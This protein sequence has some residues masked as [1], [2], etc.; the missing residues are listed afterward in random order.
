MVKQGHIFN[1]NGIIFRILSN[2]D[3]VIVYRQLG[4]PSSK[5]YQETRAN[6]EKKVELNEFIK[7]SGKIISEPRYNHNKTIPIIGGDCWRKGNTIYK[8]IDNSDGMCVYRELGFP[9]SQLFQDTY[10]DFRKKILSGE[11]R[12]NIFKYVEV[13]DIYILARTNFTYE[14]VSIDRNAMIIKRFF[15]NELKICNNYGLYE[16]AQKVRSGQFV[17]VNNSFN[18][19]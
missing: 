6:F 10:E 17:L 7:V 12:E 2:T 14:I 8:I 1:Q 19:H 3:G 18:E 5:L 16:F 4:F 11:I 13:G 9:D 15:K